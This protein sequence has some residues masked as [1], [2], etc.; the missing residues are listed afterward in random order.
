MVQEAA[1]ADAF[2]LGKANVTLVKTSLHDVSYVT[3]AF[4]EVKA[5]CLGGQGASAMVGGGYHTVEKK[6]AV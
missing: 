2:L 6:S 5:P 3:V 1:R 4:P